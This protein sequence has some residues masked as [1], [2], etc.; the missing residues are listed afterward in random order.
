M[1]E[2]RAPP[3]RWHEVLDAIDDDQVAVLRE[4]PGIAGM[5][6]AVDEAGAGRLLIFKYPWNSPGPREITSPTPSA[7]GA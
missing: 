5:Q 6:P 1:G 2:K 3:V 4:I 7:S